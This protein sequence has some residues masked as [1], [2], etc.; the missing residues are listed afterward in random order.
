MLPS[1]LVTQAGHC[2]A[3]ISHA[4]APPRLPAKQVEGIFNTLLEDEELL[5]LLFSL[6]KVS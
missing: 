5:S 2:C 1:C 3:V 6:L 4:P